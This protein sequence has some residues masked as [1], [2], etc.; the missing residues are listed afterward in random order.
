MRVLVNATLAGSKSSGLGHYIISLLSELKEF[1]IDI[2]VLA[3]HPEL[4]SG[5]FETIPV[6]GPLGPEHGGKSNRLRYIWIQTGLRG[7]LRRLQPNLLLMPTHEV[8]LGSP[9]PQIVV[10][11]DIIPFL[12]PADHRFL[13]KYYSFV[14]PHAL[15]TSAKKIIT[16][17]SSTRDDLIKHYRLQEDKVIAILSGPGLDLG[18]DDLEQETPEHFILYV[19]RIAPYKNLTG[20]VEALSIL[21]DS[22]PHHLVIAGAGSPDNQRFIS[23]LLERAERGGVADRIRFLDYVPSSQLGTL[24]KKA[25]VLVLPSFYEGFGFPPLEAMRCG[26]PVAVSRIPALVET[27]G[28]AG[29]FFEPD[30]PTDIARAIRAVLVDNSLRERLIREG[31]RRSGDFSWKKTAGKLYE[32]LLEAAGETLESLR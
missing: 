3:T 27:V 4:F 11:H 23:P 8:L 10:I 12:F 20:L 30:E 9:V 14:L 19:G 28:D 29:F 25:S 32:V 16:V 18:F 6:K 31:F 7:S 2:A 5:E 22:L 24:Y 26:T 13:G 1:P 15:R 21:R 17:S